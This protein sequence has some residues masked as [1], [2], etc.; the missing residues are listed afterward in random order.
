MLKKR[1][2]FALLYDSG[3]FCLSR[4]FRLQKVGN[5]NWLKENYNFDYISKY[6]D[7]LI[8]LDVSKQ[9]RDPTRFSLVLKELTEN[10]F[11]PIASG[12]GVMSYENAKLLLDS[13]ADKI[14]L[15]TALFKNINLVKKLASEFGQQAIIGSL[16]LK[17]SDDSYSIYISNGTE[18]IL[19][20]SKQIKDL[21][22]E[23]P[24]GEV[25]IHSIDKDGSGQGYDF[26]SIKILG[27]DFNLPIILSG[28]AGN[29]KHLI[30]G[31]LNNNVDAVSTSHLFN[32]VGDGLKQARE[33]AVQSNIELA[34]W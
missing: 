18:K 27:K 25:I 8:V 34:F 20:D 7:E 30:D 32:F 19:K 11:V 33:K 23:C 17:K 12:G 6:I 3:F 15:N 5:L 13:G 31:L 22:N 21:L 10:I 14:I 29:S 4:N 2:I 16:D 28:G 24:L 1:L 9:K 26:D